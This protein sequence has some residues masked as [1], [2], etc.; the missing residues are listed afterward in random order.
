MV[1]YLKFDIKTRKTIVFILEKK[2]TV[3]FESE[4][5][6]MTNVCLLSIYWNKTK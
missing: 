2:N 5:L 4:Q 1:F 3:L 6:K